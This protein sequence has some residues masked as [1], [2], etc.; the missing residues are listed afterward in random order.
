DLEHSLT[1]T[2]VRIVGPHTSPCRIT[3]RL[4]GELVPDGG[5]PRL[6][7]LEN[8][9][10]E[11]PIVEVL[12]GLGSHPRVVEVP[13]CGVDAGVRATAIDVPG[14]AIDRVRQPAEPSCRPRAK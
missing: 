10:A 4:H 6:G 8:R 11:I 3:E 12:D 1:N 9:H 7:E 5:F 2:E 14:G 13:H